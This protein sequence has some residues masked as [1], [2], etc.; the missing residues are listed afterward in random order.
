MKLKYKFLCRG[1]LALLGL[2]FCG[3]IVELSRSIV[4]CVEESVS[5]RVM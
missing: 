5:A 4:T 3:A 2:V 1:I